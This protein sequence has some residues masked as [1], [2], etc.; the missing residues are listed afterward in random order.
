MDL[1]S[2]IAIVVFSCSAI[3]FVGRLEHWSRYGY[4]LGLISQPFWFWALIKSKQ[5]GMFVVSLCYTYSWCQG[6]YNHWF[7]KTLKEK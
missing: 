3:W 4:I 1:I 7:V 2:Q 6:I 5:W